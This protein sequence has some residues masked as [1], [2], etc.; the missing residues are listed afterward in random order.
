MTNNTYVF[1][2]GD[3]SNPMGYAVIRCKQYSYHEAR[4]DWDNMTAAPNLNDWRCEV[5]SNH[6]LIDVW[7]KPGTASKKGLHLPP[8]DVSK[9][10]PDLLTVIVFSYVMGAWTIIA[11]DALWKF[12]M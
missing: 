3:S 6:R 12:F 10:E 4:A 7:E 11:A 5:W 9:P 1:L 2:L 8:K